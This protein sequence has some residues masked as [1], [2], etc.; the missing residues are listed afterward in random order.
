MIQRTVRLAIPQ[1]L[2]ARPCSA[3]AQAMKRFKAHLEIR[4]GDR[5]ADARSVLEMMTLTAGEGA[6]LEL[7]ASGEDEAQL[8]EAVLALL[9]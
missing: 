2:H 3:I 9:K 8:L 5:T 1:G 4:L 6:E 7:V